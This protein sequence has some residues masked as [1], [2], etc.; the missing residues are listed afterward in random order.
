MAI[1]FLTSTPNKLLSTFKK[2]IDD[3]HVDTWTYD[4]DGD[5]THIPSQ[6]KSKAWLRP[7]VVDGEKLVFKIIRPQN[8]SVPTEIYAV[9][10]G[11]FIESM[12]AHCNQLFTDARATAVAD[13][14]VGDLV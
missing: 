5:F 7:A 3:N 2:A 9:Y 14:G 1:R 12:I 11:R 6:W 10:H 4:T 13:T 8:F